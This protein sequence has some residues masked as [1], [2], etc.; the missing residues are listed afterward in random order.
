[1]VELSVIN[2]IYYVNLFIFK[3]NNNSASI[4]LVQVYGDPSNTTKKILTISFFDNNHFSVVYEY[5]KSS[6]NY[7]N[8]NY[9]KP[10]LI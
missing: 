2:L 4:K 9:M 3:E 1:M 8:L 6:Y 10:Y 7:N 5:N